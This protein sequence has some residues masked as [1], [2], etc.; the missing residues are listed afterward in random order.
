MGKKADA[1]RG[2]KMILHAM[3]ATCNGCPAKNLKLCRADLRCFHR[4]LLNLK[5]SEE[6][7]IL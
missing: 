7:A 5:K 6:R 2:R 4:F 3:T 1:E